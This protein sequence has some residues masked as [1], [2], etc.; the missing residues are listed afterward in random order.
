[1]SELT[2]ESTD[3]L[4]GLAFED[5]SVVMTS[6]TSWPTVHMGC[7]GYHDQGRLAEVAGAREEAR[8][9]AGTEV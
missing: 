9:R 8:P 7:S 5:K 4:M 6:L 3:S 2:P 1:M